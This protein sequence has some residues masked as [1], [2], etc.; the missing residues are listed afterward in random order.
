M[1][2]PPEPATTTK[3]RDALETLRLAEAKYESVLAALDAETKK[4]LEAERAAPHPATEL[5]KLKD[6]GQ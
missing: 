1:P 6:E 3:T 2:P 4:R 5:E